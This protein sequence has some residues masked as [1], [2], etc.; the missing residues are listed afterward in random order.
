MQPVQEIWPGDQAGL[1]LMLGPGPGF[2]AGAGTWSRSGLR[3]VW[4]A[5]P[6]SRAGVSRDRVQ[7]RDQP[8]LGL[9]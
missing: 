4:G 2:L 8:G 5:G 3:S 7:V 1:V 6:V 9:V